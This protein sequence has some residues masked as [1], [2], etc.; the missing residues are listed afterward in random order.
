MGVDEFDRT[1]EEHHAA[2]EAIIVGDPEPFR[3]LYS[4]AADVTLANPF[5]PPARGPAAVDETLGR[6]AAHYRDGVPRGY[7][8]VA[9]VVTSELAYTVELER[10]TARVAGVEGPQPITLRVTSIFRP[11]GGTWKLVHRH[12]DP[13]AS[14]R[15]PESV[16]DRG[17]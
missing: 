14:P 4:H 10:Y 15:S 13:I 3:R 1:I 2:L 11:E 12:A 8:T 7:E 16:V 17:R 9:K 6:A 5:G